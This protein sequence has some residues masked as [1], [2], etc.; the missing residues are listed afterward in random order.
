[1]N[2]IEKNTSIP[3][4]N[5]HIGYFEHDVIPDDNELTDYLSKV[6]L[7]EEKL[8]IDSGLKSIIISK[9]VEIFT[10]AYGHGLNKNP[11][12]LKVISCG[13]YRTKSKQLALSVLDLGGGIV[14]RVTSA[15]SFKMGSTE[16]I[17]WALVKGNSTRTDSSNDLPRGLG[18][19]ILKEFVSVNNGEIRIYSNNCLAKL[20]PSDSKYHV[21]KTDVN[22]PGT[23]VNIIINCDDKKYSF[24]PKRGHVE[25]YF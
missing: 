7:S 1:M 10:N 23:L 4:N 20:D 22:F 2:Y 17:E 8:N 5:G 18:F 16:A 12:D 9:L 13:Q 25:A 19:D 3:I 11:F 6:W 14:E 21:V 24:T 15:S